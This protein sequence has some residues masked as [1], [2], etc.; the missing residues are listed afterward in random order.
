[1]SDLLTGHNTV[2]GSALV[3]IGVIIGAII[4]SLPTL[5]KVQNERESNLL[6]ERAKDMQEM[7]KRIERLEAEQEEKD[8][9]HEADQKRKDKLFEA[10]RALYRHQINNLDGA[11]SA[12]LMLLKKGV[13]VEEAVD[14]V[15]KMRAEQL[16]RETVEKAALR[17]LEIKSASEDK[18]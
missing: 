16:A 2:L 4:R 13:A 15:E 17:A 10:E 14:A 6:I 7:R 1:V 12:L 3:L 9:K 8:T 18:Q 11:F 5:K